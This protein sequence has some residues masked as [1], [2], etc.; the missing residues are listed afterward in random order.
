MFT[1]SYLPLLAVILPIAAIVI[2]P[3]IIKDQNDDYYYSVIVCLITFLI[4]ISMWPQIKAGKILDLSLDTGLGIDFSFRSDM[5]SLYM[6]IL[7]AFLWLLSSVYAIEYMKSSHAYIRYNTFSLLSLGGMMGVVFT[8]NLFSLYIFFELLSVSSAILVFHE[9][10]KEAMKAGLKYLFLG[11]TGGLFLLFAIILT[12]SIAGTGDLTV[13]GIGLEGSSWL[14]WIFWAYI[15]GFGVKAGMFPLHIW[16]PSAHPVAPSPASALL[17]G[18]MI[19]AGAYGIL[20]TVY[21]IIGYEYITKYYTGILLILLIISL[22]TIFLGSACAISQSEIKKMLAYSSI[23]QIGYIIMGIC[24]LAYNGLVGALVHI[25]AHCLMK[26][27]LF[28]CA[29]AFIHQTGLRNLS[30]LKGIGKKMPITTFAFT[31]SALS[32][33]G[34]PPFVGFVSKWFLALGTLECMRMGNYWGGIGIISLVILLISSLL[35]LIYYGPVVIGAWMY[36]HSEHETSYK[37]EEANIVMLLP[38]ILLTFGVFIFGIFPQIP[39]TVARRI[40]QMFF[41]K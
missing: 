37:R 17:S 5:L 18:V 2:R 29:G 26:G 40:T 16:L 12:Y 15:I 23:S 10:T 11:I 20:K 3:F 24:L 25:F 32:M 22:I 14:P 8:G 9:E 13:I 7:S 41:L 38:I 30:E 27:T 19:K 35:N 33:V 39:L 4:V 34:I 28:L 21:N 1:Q 6:G 31:I 36:T